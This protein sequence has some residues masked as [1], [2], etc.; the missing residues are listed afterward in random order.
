MS[1]L[2]AIVSFLFSQIDAAWAIYTGG[3]ILG[4]AL[5]VIVLDKIFHIFDVLKR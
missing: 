4:L 3:S 2:Q 5:A 1:D